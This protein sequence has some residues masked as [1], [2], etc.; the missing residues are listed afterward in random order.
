MAFKERNICVCVSVRE[1]EP[2]T[3]FDS[4]EGR[5]AQLLPIYQM[6]KSS[7]VIYFIATVSLS[8]WLLSHLTVSRCYL[9]TLRD[10]HIASLEILWVKLFARLTITLSSERRRCYH[11]DM[12]AMNS[13]FNMI[14]CVKKTAPNN[15]DDI[16]FP[17]L[18]FQLDTHIAHPHEMYQL[19]CHLCIKSRFIDVDF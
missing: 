18:Q 7:F 11:M 16:Q 19:T 3:Q 5:I 14:E 8:Y 6:I 13:A 10:M 12:W 15:P 17:R 9:L 2:S 4:R 1:Q